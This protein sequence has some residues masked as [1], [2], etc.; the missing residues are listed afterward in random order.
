VDNGQSP[1]FGYLTK[2]PDGNLWFVAA[3]GWIGYLDAN[4]HCELYKNV[5]RSQSLI[6]M[7]T[8]VLLPSMK[9]GYYG[10]LTGEPELI[11]M[12]LLQKGFGSYYQSDGL[13]T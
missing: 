12:I 8:I 6:T 5:A 11:I 4:D 10:W 1:V 9:K 2:G 7:A 13:V 3:F